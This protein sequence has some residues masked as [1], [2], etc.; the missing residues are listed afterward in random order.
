MTKAQIH[1]LKNAAEVSVKAADL[2]QEVIQLQE[3]PVLGLATGST[4]LGMYREL[5]RRYQEGMIDFSAVHTF[6]LDEY[7]GLGSDHPQSYY[8][9][10]MKSFFEH[11]NVPREH[12][13]IPDGKPH[14]VQAYCPEYDAMIER[15]G[16]IDLQ[17]LGIGVNGHIGFNEPA[18]EL[19]PY[20]HLVRLKAETIE[21]N[22]RFFE[23]REDVPQYAITMG[24]R[25]IL[26]AKRIVL[27]AIGEDK[28]PAVAGMLNSGITTQL[29][30][31]FLQ[32][33]DQVHVIVDEAAAS[34][35]VSTSQ[36]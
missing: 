2:V 4:P 30:A 16:G 1:I 12:I 11:V 27:L 5:I 7:Y 23:R 33:H 10:M 8:Q 35:L 31:T 15:A 18:D 19:Q 34:Q 14:D 28:A 24:I 22:A 6:N 9:F 21:A 25:N 13:H 3:R 26:Q 36:P 17:I 32:L 29:P 20:T